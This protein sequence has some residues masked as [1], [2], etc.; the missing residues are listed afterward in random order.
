MDQ[1]LKE[2]FRYKLPERDSVHPTLFIGLGGA[3]GAMVDR[4]LAKLDTRWDKHKF[5]QLYHGFALDTDTGALARY[6]RIPEGNR[7]L[8]SDFDKRWYA[9]SKRG[10]SYI[11]ADPIFTQWAHSWYGFR[12]E[13][14][15]GAGQI[16]LESRMSLHYQLENDHAGIVRSLKDCIRTALHHDNPFR[17][18]SP[19]Q[20]NVNIFCSIAGGTGSGA[21]LS[22]AYLVRRLIEE[23]GNTAK[24]IGYLMLPGPFFPAV[25]QTQHVEIDANGY[26]ALKELEHLMELGLERGEGK[27]SA[28]FHYS[29]FH[30][31]ETSVNR[32]PFNFVYLL[33]APQGTAASTLTEYRD[34]VADAMFVQFFS[35]I[36]GVQNSQWDN[37][38]KLVNSGTASGYVLNYGTCGSNVLILPARDIL[39]YCAHR[40]ALDA[41]DRFMLQRD[42]SDDAAAAGFAVRTDTPEWH[43]LTPA[44]RAERLDDAFIGFVDYIASNERKRNPEGGIFEAVRRGLSAVTEQPLADA[45]R[46]ETERLLGQLD[47]QVSL[48]RPTEYVFHERDYDVRVPA[49]RLTNQVTRTRNA[50]DAAW[51][52]LRVDLTNGQMLR[53]FFDQHQ[54]S[55]LGQRYLLIGLA[56]S[57][58]E[59]LAWL[60]AEVSKRRKNADL[61][62][63][64]ISRELDTNQER[65]KSTAPQ[66]LIERFKRS[67]DDFNEARAAFL[68]WF[69][70]T[71][72]QGWQELL[73]LECEQKVTEALVKRIESLLQVFRDLIDQT[74]DARDRLE[75]QSAHI[76]RTGGLVAGES[77]SNLFAFDTEALRDE[78]AGRRLWDHY[79]ERAFRNQNAWFSPDEVLP[80]INRA[81]DP[82][83]DEH[84]ELRQP[85]VGTIAGRIVAGLL[86]AGRE[87]L[88]APIMGTEELSND[89]SKLGLMLDDALE[90]EARIVLKLSSAKLGQADE[91]AVRE[92]IDA[93]LAHAV[94]KAA[95]LCTIAPPAQ[96]ASIA[97]DASS[98]ACLHPAY[99]ESLGPRLG[100]TH[101]C[102]LITSWFDSRTVLLYSARMGIPLFWVRSVN[103]RM[104]PAYRAVQKAKVETRRYP[105]HID[106]AWEHGLDDL[107]PLE[108]ARER[109][110]AELDEVHVRFA[111]CRIGGVI[112]KDDASWRI[113]LDGFDKV[114]GASLPKAL[115]SMESMREDLAKR[116]DAPMVAL[117][118]EL[119]SPHEPV[120]AW[121]PVIAYLKGISN[122]C[123]NLPESNLLHR[124]HQI[125]SNYVR[126]YAPKDLHA[127]AD[128]YLASN[129][130]S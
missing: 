111:F 76:L 114:L 3:G 51:A 11:D 124:H 70:T 30:R 127:I 80:A 92:Y 38:S 117:R 12:A 100:D 5:G 18:T 25:P 48:D 85:D 40:Y 75:Q 14:G 23:A 29:G 10:S 97:E 68:S 71:L 103:E 67:N 2:A 1:A 16:R 99:A 31:G 81:F 36:M 108:R 73:K 107:D 115:E 126:H 58:R 46:A 91:N 20:F 122:E 44:R 101:K 79:Y 94:R 39:E 88:T 120:S 110:A 82:V 4:V 49:Q 87:K 98:M 27:R 84:G 54:V 116:L 125:I 21:F 15:V 106:S 53:N 35:P 55:L 86:D 96:D 129:P 56:R 77:E 33:D 42:T 72:V 17:L 52:N 47:V 119:E 113:K 83:A 13:S 95:A 78:G 26:A 66:T 104:K 74:V 34:A 50:V 8:L 60:S 28:T 6:S 57:L 64:E 123:L 93:K 19:L 24:T 102:K 90:L 61:D 118:A 130:G 112:H 128:P 9:D 65:L 22:F 109:Q 62:S 32:A 89:R 45:F 121:E 41:I 105:L 69:N 63:A 37:S 59:R 43:Q 7:V